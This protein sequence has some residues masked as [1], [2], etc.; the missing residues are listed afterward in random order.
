M[1]QDNSGKN[2][3][4]KETYVNFDSS[5]SDDN[6]KFGRFFES[7]MIC[8]APELDGKSFQKEISTLHPF[9]NLLPKIHYSDEKYIDFV[10]SATMKIPYLTGFVNNIEK[11]ILNI[12]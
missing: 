2:I 12:K 3:A 5:M 9:A 7:N 4:N 6:K 1:M 8:V 10:K 11:Q